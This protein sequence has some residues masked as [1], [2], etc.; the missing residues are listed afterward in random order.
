MNEADWAA[1]TQ[2]RQRT[3]PRY[4]NRC[5]PK[6]FPLTQKAAQSFCENDNTI[7]SYHKSQRCK[8]NFRWNW[9]SDELAYG[10]HNKLILCYYNIIFFFY[11]QIFSIKI[12]IVDE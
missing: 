8:Y 7:R 5:L 9:L 4:G 2:N 1:L 10:H 3:K 6:Y 11:S 12:K